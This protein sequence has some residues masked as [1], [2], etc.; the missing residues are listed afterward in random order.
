MPTIFTHPVP[1]LALSFGLGKQVV[2]RRLLVFAMLCS[3]LPDLDII[4]FKLGIAYGDI[5]GHRGASHSFAF[6]FGMGLF[7]AC[8]SPLL[9]CRAVAAFG[10]ISFT[11]ISHIVLDAMTSGGLGVAAF[12]P[13]DD[14][15]YFLPWRPIRVSP[16]NPAAFLGERGIAV[17]KSELLWVWL[18]CM[19]GAIA[20]WLARH[21]KVTIRK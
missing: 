3:V 10:V 8:I 19:V 14:T 12:W 15:R 1:A 5:W 6:A 16:I 20:L 7:A 21:V 17:L 9:R 13:L 2:S 11:I 18:P 4:G